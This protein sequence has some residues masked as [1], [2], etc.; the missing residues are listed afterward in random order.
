MTYLPLL[1]KI[2]VK[3]VRNNIPQETNHTAVAL[4]FDS[5]GEFE[6]VLRDGSRIQPYIVIGVWPIKEVMGGY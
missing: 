2:R 6:Y 1:A 5:E 4:A 3:R